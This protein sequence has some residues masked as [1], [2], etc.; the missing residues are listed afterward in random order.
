MLTSADAVLVVVDVQGKLAQ[1]MQDRE[2]LFA[3]LSKL[4]RGARA[5]GLPVIWVEQN[6]AG[7]GP[8]VPEVAAEMPPGLAPIPKRSFSCCGELRF[9][10]ALTACARRQVLLCGIESH[11][12]IYQTARD[13]A[14]AGYEV[15][16]VADAVSSRTA[17]NREMGLDCSQKAG[18][19]ATTVEM[20]LFEMLGTAEG[21][22]FK[23]VVG[24][25]R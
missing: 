14:A 8:T 5:L 25:V 20:G 6:P 3:G 16:V 12:C 4:L 24:I 7:L 10:A 17:L 19:R 13:L 23:R 2:A 22:A 18:A 11:V 21:E 15:Y 1:L 9:T